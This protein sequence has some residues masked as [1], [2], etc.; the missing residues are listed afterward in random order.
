M[1]SKKLYHYTSIV[2]NQAI[3]RCFFNLGAIVLPL[4][5]VKLPKE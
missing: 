2:S 4:V 3:A 5:F 1:A